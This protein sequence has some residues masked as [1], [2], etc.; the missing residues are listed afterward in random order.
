MAR[1]RK[2]KKLPLDYIEHLYKRGYSPAMIAWILQKDFD[3]NIS[4]WTVWRRLR[5][6][7]ANFA[8]KHGEVQ[9]RKVG[10]KV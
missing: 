4:R 2:P 3:I 9:H 10:V 7:G 5:D 8:T 1:G 6:M